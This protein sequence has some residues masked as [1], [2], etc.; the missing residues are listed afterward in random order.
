MNFVLIDS[1]DGMNV[2][3]FIKIKEQHFLSKIKNIHVIDYTMK[4]NMLVLIIIWIFY[5]NWLM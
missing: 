1:I 3:F 2:I 5:L 4:L